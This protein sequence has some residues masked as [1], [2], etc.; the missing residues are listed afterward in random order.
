MKAGDL[1]RFVFDRPKVVVVFCPDPDTARRAVLHVYAGAKGIPVW[2]FSTS[3]P[4]PDL[5]GM[6]HYVAVRPTA[7]ALLFDAI[8]RLSGH[9]VA[10]SVAAWTGE[11]G[12][13]LLKL[14][15]F[16]LPPFRVLLLNRHGDFFPGTPGHI[17][18]HNWTRLRDLLQL[19]LDHARAKLWRFLLRAM[20][21]REFV[22]ALIYRRRY[23]VVVFSADGETSRFAVRHV[24]ARIPN[25]PV[26]LFSTAPPFGDVASVCGEIV[27]EPNSLVLLWRA[28]RRLSG[29]W[30]A[31]GVSAWTGEHGHWLTK[32]APFLIPPFRTIVLNRHGDFFDGDLCGIL[33]HNWARLRD[34]LK[35][36][37]DLSRAAFLAFLELCAP[38]FRAIF[39]RL[40]G[41]ERVEVPASAVGEGVDLFV[42]IGEFWDGDALERFAQASDARWILAAGAGFAQAGP[43]AG[44]HVRALGTAV[45]ARMAEVSLPD[46]AV[47]SAPARRGSARFGAGLRDDPGG[48]R[49]AAGARDSTMR[50]GRYVVADPVLAGG[51]RGM[52]VVRNRG[53]AAAPR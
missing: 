3:P 8:R 29:C 9:W 51:C 36:G 46:G 28:R 38:V 53:R 2:L 15:P 6:C 21:P 18:R 32:L 31:L 17:A 25:L 23:V 47:S 20:A 45:R 10:L 34:Q 26:L 11:R 39:R 7:R 30:V 43:R 35:L 13:W 24:R 40:Q 44:R 14:A 5:L 19:G 1:R 4:P 33:R 37:L 42:Q 41:D 12:R 50:P 27:I 52:G 49:Q 22:N 16:L 48:P